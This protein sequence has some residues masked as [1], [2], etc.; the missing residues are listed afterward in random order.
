MP[1]QP[2][3]VI[4]LEIY[5]NFYCVYYPSIIPPCL[6]KTCSYGFKWINQAYF[7]MKSACCS[8]RGIVHLKTK[9]HS[10]STHHYANGGVGVSGGNSIGAESNT[11][12]VNCVLFFRRN[13]TTEKTTCL[14]P[15]RVM[16]SSDIL[17]G[18][19]SPSHGHTG[20][21]H[22]LSPKGVAMSTC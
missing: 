21:V 17:L 8:F 3:N 18:A 22:T 19:C 11:I 1:D 13:K 4:S 7:S 5:H 20:K 6:N 15:A 14:H 16:S 12:E 9:I 2:A 10:L